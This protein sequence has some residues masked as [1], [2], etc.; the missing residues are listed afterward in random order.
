[1]HH[2]LSILIYLL[3]AH[4][5]CDFPWQ[6]EFLSKGKHYKN[7]PYATWMPWYCC[8][9]AH[10]VIHGAAV[11]FI[12]GSV[13]LAVVEMMLHFVTDIGKNA[14]W[15]SGRTDQVLHVCV[16]VTYAA[17]CCMYTVS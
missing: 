4:F 6:G 16:K 12:T 17:V 7:N 9:I 2:F 14:G 3:G 10:V 5:L 15:V 1:M 13:V 8:M 11:Q